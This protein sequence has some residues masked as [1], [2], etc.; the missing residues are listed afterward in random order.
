M[1]ILIPMAGAG[2]RFVQMGFKDPKPLIDVNG[3]PMIRRVIDNLGT[4][5]D[6][7]F[8]LQK[9][10]LE[11]YRERL[12]E[13]TSVCRSAKFLTVDQLTEGAAQTCLIARSLLKGTESLMIANCDQIMDWDHAAFYSWFDANPSDG[14][15]LTFTSDSDK[16]SYV[17][18]NADGWVTEAKEKI[19][20]SNLAT[21]GVYIWRRA[22]DFISAADEMIAKNIRHNNEFYVCPVY[23]QNVEAGLH[24]NTYHIERHWPIGTPEDLEV[25]LN[26][27]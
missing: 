4:D 17:T 6:Y 1:Q 11:N 21:T 7:I 2:S 14:S 3:L 19:V 26:N 15:I 23:N 5:H 16:N 18:V 22:D 20:I 25:Y 9:S 27:A 12:T 13:V 10:T 24:I 8:I